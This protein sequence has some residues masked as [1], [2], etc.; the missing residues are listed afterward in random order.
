[1]VKRMFELHPSLL[2]I[3]LLL[4]V[5]CAV[6]EATRQKSAQEATET[7][8]KGAGPKLVTGVNDLGFKLLQTSAKNSATAN[9]LVSP[10]S[11]DLALGLVQSGAAG[12]T[13][14]EIAKV[15]GVEGVAGEDLGNAQ[16]SLI[17]LLQNAD[18]K[19]ALSIANSLWLQD[20][21]SFNSDYLR[22]NAD[23]FQAKIATTDFASPGGVQRVNEWVSDQTH[24]H[25]KSIL[26]GP[27]PDL[28]L[29]ALNAM[30]F[31][32]KWEHPFKEDATRSRAF[33]LAD[34]KTTEA[35]MMHQRG[36]YQYLKGDGMQALSMPYGDG[37]LA[38]LIALP[39]DVGG[40]PK[41]VSQVNADGWSKW[42]D[43]MGENEANVTV[44]R[45]KFEVTNPLNGALKAQG[46]TLAF[47]RNAA[48][49]SPMCSSERLFVS[50]VLQKATIEVNEEGT[51]ATVVTSVG[52][53]AA[54]AMPRRI[55]VVNFVADHPFLY[56]IYETNT[57]VILFVG[58]LNNPSQAATQ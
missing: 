31:K 40:L 58:T 25:I 44:P 10:I 8:T 22:N 19:V 13:K 23:R 29:V 15:L 6:S 57:K 50:Q 2:G 1:M 39:D 9:L 37:R 11:A 16:S 30:Y 26:G 55:D 20:G 3:V 35:M 43:Q 41:L 28:R 47:D 34:G 18:P 21:V 7:L 17:T 33:K 45:F 53:Q 4:A 52:M 54:S 38:M 24:G 27:D 36:S 42:V 5:G 48:D 51:E 32:G 56:A 49:F 46:M 12:P 14:D